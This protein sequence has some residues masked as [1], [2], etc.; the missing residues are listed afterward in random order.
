[1]NYPNLSEQIF[2]DASNT[3]FINGGS[4][5]IDNGRVYEK[6]GTSLVSRYPN[7][8]KIDIID[9]IYVKSNHF[10]FWKEISPYLPQGCFISHGYVPPE[11]QA[12]IGLSLYE[13]HYGSI[14]VNDI[15]ASEGSEGNPELIGKYKDIYLF[16]IDYP[17]LKYFLSNK[18]INWAL[19][20]TSVHQRGLALDIT[21]KEEYYDIFVNILQWFYL[22]NKDE[23]KL[24]GTFIKQS[25]NVMHIEFLEDSSNVQNFVGNSYFMTNGVNSPVSS[26]LKGKEGRFYE[27]MKSNGHLDLADTGYNKQ[28]LAK[29][30]NS[31]KRHNSALAKAIKEILDDTL[32]GPGGII[33][34]L[35]QSQ[36]DYSQSLINGLLGAMSVVS[37][38]LDNITEGR[39]SILIKE[40]IESEIEKT[41]DNILIKNKA[42][43]LY[44]LSSDD[45][46]VLMIKE[47]PTISDSKLKI[48][49][50]RIKKSDT[51]RSISKTDPKK[52]PD[53]T[54]PV[55]DSLRVT[56]GIV[57]VTNLPFDHFSDINTDFV[58]NLEKNSKKK[59]TTTVNNIT[60]KL[61]THNLNS[62]DVK[63]YA[64][65]S[66][67][68]LV[69]FS[70]NTKDSNNIEISFNT[71]FSGTIEV[72]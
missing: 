1:M 38:E 11:I 45:S 40:A 32:G 24:S 41:S 36:L 2:K 50:N 37:D 52:T 58:I 47:T 3:Y 18:G 57:H 25:T 10:K 13:N 60:T 64:K 71:Q 9:G 30:P 66:N 55:Y 5:V 62:S 72:Y 65:D 22:N 27:I 29:M 68:S 33:S 44:P 53:N 39:A 20:N 6:S 12:R 63:A 21:F 34:T 19:P 59:Y 51:N 67:G 69:V 31:A 15:L 17:K 70:Q 23:L 42:L 35:V 54:E 26:F 28:L 4:Q 48:R 49:K 7:Y 43:S 46:D 8:S 14:K 56:D 61:I 16:Q